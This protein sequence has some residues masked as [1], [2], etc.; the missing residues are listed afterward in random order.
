[1]TSRSIEHPR[2]VMIVQARMG[3]K[4]LPGK[5]LMPLAGKPLVSRMLERLKRCE[6]VEAI[7][8]ATTTRSEDDPLEQLALSHGVQAFRG[9]EDDL[10]DRYYHAARQAGG[11]VIVRVPG[12]NATPDPQQIDR[13]IED[14]LRSDNDFTT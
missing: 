4:R 11:N 10:V 6:K 5:S 14:H 7:V 9:A 2:V 12:D 3:S 1:M 8:L 13:I